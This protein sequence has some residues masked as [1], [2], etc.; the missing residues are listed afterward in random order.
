MRAG[1][2]KVER[3]I[4]R[5]GMRDL[6]DMAHLLLLSGCCDIAGFPRSANCGKEFFPFLSCLH[7]PPYLLCPACLNIITGQWIKFL[8]LFQCF[9][10]IRFKSLILSMLPVYPTF[11]P[12]HF[13][14]KVCFEMCYLWQA[15][16]FF[17]SLHK[18]LL[19]SMLDK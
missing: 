10:D 16:L 3:W 8:F 17:F 9:F 13:E 4:E 12:P 2:S 7:S 14:V 5:E 1:G 11:F 19:I 6:T 15:K 18:T